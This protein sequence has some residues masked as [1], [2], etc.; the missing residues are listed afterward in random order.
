MKKEKETKKKNGR[1]ICNTYRGKCGSTW[2][3]G[4]SDEELADEIRKVPEW[5]ADL[6]RDLCYRANM[7]DEWE[8]AEDDFESVAFAAAE[9]LGVEIL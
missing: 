1:K 5:D 6:L 2:V 8:A 7:L 4:L 3:C 9:K